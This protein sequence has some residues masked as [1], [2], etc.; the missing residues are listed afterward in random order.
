MEILDLGRCGIPRVVG[1]TAALL[2]LVSLGEPL[3]GGSPEDGLDEY[4]VKAA[5][6]YNFAKFVEWPAGT[7]PTSKEPLAICVLG[8]NPFGHSLE[9]AVTG[10][11]VEGRPLIIR[12][13]TN[14]KQITACQMLFIASAEG[15]RATP[16]IGAI[17]TQGVLTIEDSDTDGTAGEVINLRLARGKVRFDINVEAAERA[18]LRISSR[19]LAL[20]RI[21]GPAPR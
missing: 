13:I 16:I 12:Y 11:A 17:N 15:K 8:Q 3:A 14:V 7:F 4:Q 1:C 6:L 5:F 9:D 21:I 20:A 2:V 19:L 10:K 18:K